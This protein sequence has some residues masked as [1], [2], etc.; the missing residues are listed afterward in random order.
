[1]LMVI[2]YGVGNVGSIRNMIRHVG[3]EAITVKD[4]AELEGASGIILPGVGKF[5]RGM[6]HLS[7]GGWIDALNRCVI[8]Q[9]VP[10]L[11][12]CLGMQLMTRGSE[13]SPGVKGLGWVAADTLRFQ[14]EAEDRLRVPH[15]GWNIVKPVAGS[16]LMDDD[17][18]EKRF[19]F[20]H[21]YHV[22]CDQDED[23]AG[24]TFYGRRFVS[25]IQR[26]NLFGFQPHPEKSHRFGMDVFRKFIAMSE[27]TC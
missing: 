18:E 17:Y 23:V 7:E 26:G 20:V 4:P 10:T 3:R 1:M 27:P 16:S 2:D 25:A 24:T 11:G 6:K 14:F 9:Q 12:I 15:M 22:V 19:Y 8:E 21:S 13:E 5:G